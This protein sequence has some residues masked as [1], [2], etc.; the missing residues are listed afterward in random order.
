MVYTLALGCAKAWGTIRWLGLGRGH[1][2]SF[3][4]QRE[5][6]TLTGTLVHVSFH[7]LHGF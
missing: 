3:I 5:R 1:P 7:A 4:S 6:L 2:G